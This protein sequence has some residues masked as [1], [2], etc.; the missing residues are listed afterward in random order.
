MISR[1]WHGYTSLANAD[2]YEN[3][4]NKEIFTGIKSR[5]INGF[6]GIDLLRRNL[7]LEVEFMT[8]MWFDNIES[9]IEFAGLEYENAVVPEKAQKLLSR[10]DKQSQHYQVRN[11]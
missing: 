1:I 11:Q 6:I 9:V 8:I 7:D 2:A 3:L 5:D 10:F 4:L